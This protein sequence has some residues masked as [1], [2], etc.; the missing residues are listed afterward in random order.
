MTVQVDGPLMDPGAL[1]CHV[2]SPTGSCRGICC[3][4]ESGI[5][6]VARVSTMRKK[7]RPYAHDAAD[8]EH[9]DLP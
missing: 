7:G 1:C 3:A 5:R 6:P 4:L 9:M 2:S 8:V